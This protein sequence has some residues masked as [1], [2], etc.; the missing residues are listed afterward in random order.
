M[1]ATSTHDSKRSE[2]V[3]AR[4]NVISEM[5]D[6]WDAILQRWSRLNRG[7][8]FDV[9]CIEA[10][11][12]NDEV[13]LYQTL[14]GTWPLVVPDEAG[15]IDYRTR[16][17][18]YMIKALRE[19]KEH[20]S[21]IKVNTDYENAMRSF[22]EAVLMPGETNLFLADFEL[23]VQPIAHFGLLNSLAQTLIKLASPGVPDIYQGCEL[24]QFNLVDPDN[25]RPVDFVRR[26]ELLAEV[27]ALAGA[28]PEQWPQRLRPLLADMSDG[29]IKLYLVWQCLA[30]RERWP[31]LF[32]DGDYLPLTVT[33]ERA[34]HV[35]VFARSYGNRALI[36]LVPRLN[37]GLM[38][39]L[40]LLP[41][42][43]EVWGDTAVELPG[44]LAGCEW[45]NVFT[46]E[47]HPVASSL[48]VGRLL[49]CFPEALLTSEASA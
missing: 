24:W 46:G 41:M 21:W 34:A 30:Q 6:K 29:R 11:S 15:L 7:R 39:E 22:V 4:L 18:A 8:K 31:D 36:A 14:I 32:R 20:T 12:R 1:L 38:S 5:P 27:K 44:G 3:R 45:T 49:T 37:V 9:D 43:L 28:P 13:L 2:D 40:P 25:R 35:C 47:V 26:Q 48:A 17:D 42:G 10:P 16:I 33:G 19:A 23:L